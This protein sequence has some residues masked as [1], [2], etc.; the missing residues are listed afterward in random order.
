MIAAAAPALVAALAAVWI[1]DR[2][3][4]MS[5]LSFAPLALTWA[6]LAALGAARCLPLAGSPWADPV[7]WL[8]RAAMLP[9]LLGLPAMLGLCGARGWSPLA[10]LALHGG[11][12]LLPLVGRRPWS[13]RT[14]A[15]L[16]G[17][18]ALA[19][20]A[21]PGLDGLMLCSA[22]QALACGAAMAAPVRAA[23][24]LA[25]PACLAATLALGL[26]VL[27]PGLP[28]LLLLQAGLGLAAG[29]AALVHIGASRELASR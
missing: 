20:G 18:S 4:P 21:V 3:W 23:S 7:R 22:L 14:V 19:W 10:V 12:M 15:A 9:M 17:A 6:A 13:G 5:L 8:A 16:M 2:W 28:A 29:A 25:L 1:G 24:R 26:L 27:G 11:L